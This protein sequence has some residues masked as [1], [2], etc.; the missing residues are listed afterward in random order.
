LLFCSILRGNQVRKKLRDNSWNHQIFSVDL[1]GNTQ[2]NKDVNW[3]TIC[4]IWLAIHSKKNCTLFLI[5][6]HSLHISSQFASPSRRAYVH[7][8]RLLSRDMKTVSHFNS[9]TYSLSSHRFFNKTN[10][11]SFSNTTSHKQSTHKVEMWRV[12]RV[13][14]LKKRLKGLFF[15]DIIWLTPSL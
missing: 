7:F 2:H 12:N 4:I 8:E 6:Q 9:V 5:A 10:S 1:Y 13:E 15:L 14:K 3:T 11:F